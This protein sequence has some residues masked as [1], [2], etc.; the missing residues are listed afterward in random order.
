MPV[1]KI[2]KVLLV[3]AALVVNYGAVRSKVLDRWVARNVVLGRG[4][5]LDRSVNLGNDDVLFRGK[6]AADLFEGWG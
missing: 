2:D 5:G 6:V 1:D 4:D 3:A